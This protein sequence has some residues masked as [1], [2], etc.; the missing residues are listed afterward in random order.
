MAQATSNPTESDLLKVKRIFR[1]VLSTKDYGLT[2]DWKNDFKLYCY[3]DASYNC[4]EDGKSHHGY[5]ISLGKR[6]GSFCAKPAKIS[7]VC[8]SSTE[9][10]YVACCYA[11]QELAYVGK[12]LRQL[13]FHTGE[14]S[15]MMEDN[16]SSIEMTNGILVIRLINISIQ[17][18]IT[19]VNKWNVVT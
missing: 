8:I 1:H 4:Y 10:D 9:A 11:A 17:S 14:P 2:Y 7:L 12:L 18:L 15:I 6:N 16:M 19:L 13:G 5:S 3:L